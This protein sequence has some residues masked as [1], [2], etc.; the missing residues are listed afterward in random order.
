[1]VYLAIAAFSVLTLV[2]GM[3][4]WALVQQRKALA[5]AL[6]LNADRFRDVEPE[7]ML[8]LKVLEPVVVAKRESR[9]ARV[10]ADRLPVMVTKMV[11]QRVMQEVAEEMA[12][13][14]IQVE[15]KIEYR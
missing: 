14:D 11:Y 3:L 10:V 15:M 9:S 2:S 4:C 5:A 1:M 8:T 6:E 13:R 7:M 12:Q